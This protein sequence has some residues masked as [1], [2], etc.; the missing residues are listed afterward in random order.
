M[1]FVTNLSVGR[2]KLNLWFT[3]EEMDL[4]KSNV[5]VDINT[6]RSSISKNRIPSA[7]HIVGL[8]KFLA[9]DLT[10]EYTTRREKLKGEILNEGRWQQRMGCTDYAENAE[11]LRR[12]SAENSEWARERAQAAAKFL[13]RDQEK[14]RIGQ[15][16]RPKHG[17]THDCERFDVCTSSNHLHLTLPSSLQAKKRSRS[18][19]PSRIVLST[20]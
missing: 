10:A 16:L 4:F 13:E 7:D 17:P 18:K 20:R 19:S 15:H 14:G 3:Q 2:H 11:R 12:I 1:V 6:I 8:E 5:A 9:P